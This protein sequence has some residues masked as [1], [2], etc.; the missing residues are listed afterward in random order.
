M[1][2]ERIIENL[3]KILDKESIFEDDSTR[4][5]KATDLY[6]LRLY[7]NMLDGSLLYQLWLYNQKMQKKFQKY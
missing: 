5:Q 4:S 2:K 3:Y 1:E 6:A 7:Q